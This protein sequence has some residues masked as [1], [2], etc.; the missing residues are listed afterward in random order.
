MKEV[1]INVAL[2]GQLHRY[3]KELADREHRSLRGQIAYML[4]KERERELAEESA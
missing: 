2:T 3:L 4:E 1:R